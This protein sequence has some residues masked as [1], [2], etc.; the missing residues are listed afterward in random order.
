MDHGVHYQVQ[1]FVGIQGGVE[2]GADFLQG[3]ELLPLFGLQ[4]QASLE[5][6]QGALG[7]GEQAH[8]FGRGFHQHARLGGSHKRLLLAVGYFIEVTD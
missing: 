3:A 5:V 6:L 8:E 4:L 2:G 1:H 7:G